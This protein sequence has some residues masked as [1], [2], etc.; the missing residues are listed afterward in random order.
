VL[1]I[2]VNSIIHLWVKF[3][4]K[5]SDPYAVDEGMVIAD[6]LLG[7]GVTVSSG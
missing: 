1:L 7:D 3:P 4:E 6:S 5:L 2:N